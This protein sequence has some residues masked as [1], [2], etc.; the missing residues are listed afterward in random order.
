MRTVPVAKISLDASGHPVVKP[1]LP[2]TEDFE[3]IWRAARSTRWNP[4]LRSLF[5]VGDSKLSLPDSMR[6]ILDS[7][8][9][10]YGCKLVLTDDT[11]WTDIPTSLQWQLRDAFAA[12]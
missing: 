1:A 7:T 10:E 12:V 6:C 8:S 9:S 4:E 3:F 5:I 2:S 11:D